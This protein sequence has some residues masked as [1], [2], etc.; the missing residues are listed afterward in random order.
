MKAEEAEA[1]QDKKKTAVAATDELDEA[2]AAE[3][4]R[5][6]GLRRIDTLGSI[7]M[8]NSRVYQ[9]WYRR[10]KFAD[11][12]RQRLEMAADDS[13]DDLYTGNNSIISNMH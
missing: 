10:P 2:V 12:Q 4:Q 8:E 1:H 3:S 7:Q 5:Q 6:R 13:D 11:M 9:E